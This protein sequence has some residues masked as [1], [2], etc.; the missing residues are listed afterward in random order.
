MGGE[1]KKQ[2]PEETY[3]DSYSD[4]LLEDAIKFVLD[5]ARPSISS[6]QRQFRIGYNRAAHIIE[7]MESKGIVSAPRHDGTRAITAS[8]GAAR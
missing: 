3:T 7:A 6:I 1:T 2:T 5:T 8:A 4:P